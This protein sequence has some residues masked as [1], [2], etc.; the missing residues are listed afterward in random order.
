MSRMFYRCNSLK[1]LVLSNFNTNNVTDISEIF[2]SCCG[3]EKLNLYYFNI[4]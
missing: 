3:L 4:N 2:Y 1:E